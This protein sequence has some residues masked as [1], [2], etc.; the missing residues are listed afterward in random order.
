[1]IIQFVFF[2][3]NFQ[4][5]FFFQDIKNFKNNLNKETIQARM[6]AFYDKTK[7][8]LKFYEKDGRLVTVDS[9][10]SDVGYVKIKEVMNNLCKKKNFQIH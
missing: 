2:L 3:K 8:L 9:P 7:P 1:M 4:F 6:K 5:L 10:T